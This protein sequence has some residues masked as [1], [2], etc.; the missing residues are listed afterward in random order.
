MD[1]NVGPFKNQSVLLKPNNT[2]ILYIGQMHREFIVVISHL[3]TV[4]T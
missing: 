4:V 2:F 3:M 1:D